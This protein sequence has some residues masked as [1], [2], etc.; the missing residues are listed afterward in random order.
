MTDVAGHAGSGP[1]ATVGFLLSQLGAANA[2]WFHETLAPTG[3]QPRHLAILRFI[4]MEE[5]QTQSALGDGLQIAPS[6]MVALIDELEE[7][8]LVERRTNPA[9]RRARALYLTGHGRKALAAAM[10][11]AMAHERKLCAPLGDAERG[12]LIAMLQ[13]LAEHQGLT[14]GVH[15]E[16][17]TGHS[18]LDHER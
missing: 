5:G 4:A 10:K 9:D 12:Q 18:P 13:R 11:R 15:P 1:W 14:A 6:R 16:L 7:R 3:L 8:D 17:R 2:R